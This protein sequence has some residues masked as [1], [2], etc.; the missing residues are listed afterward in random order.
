MRSG[1]YFGQGIADELDC[2]LICLDEKNDMRWNTES[3]GVNPFVSENRRYLEGRHVI[4]A[5]AVINTGKTVI[6]IYKELEK[7]SKKTIIAS[8]VI[9]SDSVSM[10]TGIDFYSVRISENKFIGSKTKM[11]DGIYGPDTGDRL[12]CTF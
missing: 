1:L 4:I 3:D 6:E 9:Q 8:C 7:Y 10:F 5:D 2:T 11:Q 12:F